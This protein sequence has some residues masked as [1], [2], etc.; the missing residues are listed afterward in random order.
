M[1]RGEMTK[2]DEDCYLEIG[3]GNTIKNVHVYIY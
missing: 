1:K 2:K 3:D